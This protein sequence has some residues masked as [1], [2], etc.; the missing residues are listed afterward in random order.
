MSAIDQLSEEEKQSVI[1]QVNETFEKHQSKAVVGSQLLVQVIP[2][3][4]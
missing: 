3:L 1:E 2:V 4:L